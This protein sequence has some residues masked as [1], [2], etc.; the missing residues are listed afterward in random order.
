MRFFVIFYLE[1]FRRMGKNL[2]LEG[3]CILVMSIEK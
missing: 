3:F 1:V 2:A